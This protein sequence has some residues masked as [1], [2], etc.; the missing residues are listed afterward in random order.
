VLSAESLRA[1]LS[2]LATGYA[3]RAADV[4]AT[5]EGLDDATR[6]SLAAV[7]EEVDGASARARRIGDVLRSLGADRN[8]VNECYRV[9][10]YAGDA[11]KELASNPLFAYFAA[12]RAGEPL[13]KWVHYFPI[14]ERHMAGYRSTAARVLE[15]GVYRGGGLDLLRHYLGPEAYLAG[16]DIDRAAKRAVRGRHP[17]EL[18][19]QADPDFLRAVSERH[20]P[21]DLVIDDGGHTMRQQI[22]SVETL[23]PLLT[24]GGIYLVEDCH[25]S[26]WPEYA[27]EGEGTTFIGWLKERVDDL[28]AYHHSRDDV[29][30]D[31]WQTTLAAMHLYDSV[32]VLERTRRFAPFSEIAGT[33]EFVNLTRDAAAADI[34][35][36]AQV[37]AA[38][39]A[40]TRAEDELRMMRGELLDANNELAHVRGQLH[41]SRG[42]IEQMRRSASWRVTEPL[43]RVRSVLRGR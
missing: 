5:A 34:Q 8:M 33:A 18:G 27:A 15:I 17:V 12:N 35:L 2:A 23:F 41:R 36:V 42:T 22:V 28:H 20:G 9:A 7:L 6:A 30:A 24:E 40:R 31:P 16:V 39:S 26:Y 3:D 19:D 32:A 1:L 38:A 14:Y 21:F 29:L 13:D 25:T 43:R 4:V 10:F 11:W 37:D